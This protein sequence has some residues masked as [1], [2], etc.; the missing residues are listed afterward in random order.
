[1]GLPFYYAARS[2]STMRQLL[3]AILLC[4]SLTAWADPPKFSSGGVIFGIQYGYGFWLPDKAGLE[5]Q[6][7]PS[8]SGPDLADLQNTHT[9]AVRLG[10]NILGHVTLE[11]DIV[12]TGWNLTTT[13]RGGGGFATGVIA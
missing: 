6:L 13:D 3:I 1:M 9:V 11:A 4:S 5:R 10:Y 7:A 12:A 8:D 2:L